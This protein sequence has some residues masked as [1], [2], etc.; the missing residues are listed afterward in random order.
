M[1]RFNDDVLLSSELGTM[2]M[3]YA[4]PSL[5]N[6]QTTRLETRLG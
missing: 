5:R 4:F 1:G 6:S 2:G 3:E